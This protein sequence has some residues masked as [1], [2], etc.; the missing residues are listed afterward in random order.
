MREIVCVGTADEV[1]ALLDRGRELI[2]AVVA[3]LDLEAHRLPAT[4]PF[5]QPAKQG[6]HLYQ[7]LSPVKHETVVDELA[8]ASTNR[9]HEHFADAFDIERQGERAHS[10]CVAF[11]LERWLG[12]VAARWGANPDTWPDPRE[13]VLPDA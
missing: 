2:D 9:H 11:G 3:A 7:R 12:V 13:A 10:G 1:S 8:I 6:R 4:D 5:F